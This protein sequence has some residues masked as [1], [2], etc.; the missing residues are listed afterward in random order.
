MFQEVDVYEK[1]IITIKRLAE[2][3]L[4]QISMEITVTLQQFSLIDPRGPVLEEFWNA[5]PFYVNHA[6]AL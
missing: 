4:V 6:V 5:S 1:A 2:V 3:E